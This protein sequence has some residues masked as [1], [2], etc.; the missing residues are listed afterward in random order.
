MFVYFWHQFTKIIF[1]SFVLSQSISWLIRL[2]NKRCRILS[3]HEILHR[4]R[5]SNHMINDLQ[6]YHKAC[7]QNYLC[8]L[9]CLRT[10]F[11]GRMLS[12]KFSREIEVLTNVAK[13]LCGVIFVISKGYVQK[14]IGKIF[15]C[16]QHSDCLF[17][18]F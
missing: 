5:N 2:L 15:I 9:F 10:E 3:E 4:K 11:N 8:Q 17:Y 16:Y 1:K 14:L 13:C 12:Y 6:M 7:W 18:F